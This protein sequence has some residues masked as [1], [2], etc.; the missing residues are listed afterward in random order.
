MELSEI[1]AHG[2]DIWQLSALEETTQLY[3]QFCFSLFN[4][5]THSSLTLQLPDP[6]TLAQHF[7]KFYLKDGLTKLPSQTHYQTIA[8]S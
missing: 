5:L 6:L 1:P 4:L 2:K 7:N 8:T 3:N